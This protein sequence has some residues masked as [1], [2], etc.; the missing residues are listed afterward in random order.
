[1]SSFSKLQ[2]CIQINKNI[3]VKNKHFIFIIQNKNRKHIK[4][5][6]IK[7]RFTMYV[8]MGDF[9]TNFRHGYPLVNVSY[10]LAS[11]LVDESGVGIRNY[12]KLSPSIKRVSNSTI[13]IIQNKTKKS[14]T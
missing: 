14:N 6:K 8:F 9:S 12:A 1:V 7:A 2:T 11:S 4:N 13:G 5:K 3:K 10:H